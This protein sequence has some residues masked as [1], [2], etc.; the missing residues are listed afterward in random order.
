MNHFA[1]SLRSV[2]V[3]PILIAVAG[4][5]ISAQGSDTERWSRFRGPNGSGVGDAV[6]LPVKFAPGINMS[7]KTAVPIGHSSPIIVGDRIFRTGF[8]EKDLLVVLALDRETGRQLW[9]QQITRKRAASVANPYNN[10]ASS[11]PVSDGQNVYAFFQDFGLV[12]YSIDGAERWTLPL[13][14]FR[15]NHGMGA[16]PIVYRDMLIQICDQ[17]V[18]SYLLFVDKNTGKLRRRIDRS[19]MLGVSFSTPTVYERAGQ[20]PLLIVPGS[21]EMVAYRLDTGEKQWWL[22]GL[23][24]SPRSVPVLAKDGK[25]EDLVILNVQSAVDGAGLEVPGY[26]D[27]LARYDASHDGKLDRAEVKGYGLLAGGFPQIDINGDGYVTDKEWQFRID[28]FRIENLLVAVRA[29]SSGAI[30]LS[31]AV[32]KYRKSVPNVPS[33][34]VYRNVMYLLKEGG[35]LTSMDPATGNIY[36]QARL[37]GALEPYFASPVAADGKLYMVSQQGKVVVIRAGG[38]WDVLAINDLDEE[39]FATPAISGDSL[40]IH[41]RTALYRFRQAP[42]PSE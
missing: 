1:M 4:V 27:L 18:E 28:V 6:R 36:K 10:P 39:C 3:V 33:P 40:F 19:E 16:S 41:T 38:D 14:P 31:S 7:W 30:S 42:Q 23:P 32:W 35:I 22:S 13:G 5:L 12:S 21:F 34:I 8:Q 20:P 26:A 2:P 11:S 15:S 9:R 24:Y 37:T 25:G 17:D 29:N